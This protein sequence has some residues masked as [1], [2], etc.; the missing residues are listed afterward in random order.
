MPDWK[1]KKSVLASFIKET[2]LTFASLFFSFTIYISLMNFM[3]VKD[4]K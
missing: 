4:L 2:N 1:N 3:I